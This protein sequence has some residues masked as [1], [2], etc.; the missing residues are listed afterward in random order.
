MYAV[1]HLHFLPWGD[2]SCAPVDDP[3]RSDSILQPPGTLGVDTGNPD[4]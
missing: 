4:K 3:Q 1:T 2:F